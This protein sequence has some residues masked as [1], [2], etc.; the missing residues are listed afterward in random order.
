MCG[1]Q[2]IR[3]ASMRSLLLFKNPLQLPPTT[4]TGLRYFSVKH[5]RPRMISSLRPDKL[6]PTDFQESLPNVFHRFYQ[7]PTPQSRNTHLGLRHRGSCI[8]WVPA[9]PPERCTG[10]L[11]Y[12]APYPASSLVG[13][14]RFR[15][16]PKFDP[17]SAV[18]PQAAFAAGSDLQTPGA[19]GMPWSVPLWRLIKRADVRPFLDVLPADG[20]AVPDKWP[21]GKGLTED[22]LLIYALGQP[23][24]VE[25]H[26]ATL[27]VHINSPSPGLVCARIEPGFFDW[28]LKTFRQPYAGMGIMSLERLANG[29]VGLHLQ[30]ILSLKQDHVNQS[31]AKPVEGAI[32]PLELRPVL[33][34]EAT[35]P[36][37]R[38]YIGQK[39]WLNQIF[40]KLPHVS[41]MDDVRT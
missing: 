7:K 9:A 2:R 15:L 19:D 13:S 1:G 17:A 30:K 20:M 25:F 37:D 32:R 33:F 8:D 11:Y 40:N 35:K 23:F 16:T 10:F 6:R 26:M 3:P 38:R 5:E 34:K 12:H 41:E 27:R 21:P 4:F 39:D 24:L 29:T 22:S 18:S 36:T 28:T 31:I 14:M